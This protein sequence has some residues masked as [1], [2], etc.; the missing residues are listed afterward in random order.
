MIKKVF[1]ILFTF[2]LF[3]SVCRIYGQIHDQIYDDTLPENV[4]SFPF[5]SEDYRHKITY[6][7]DNSVVWSEKK[8]MAWAT[9]QGFS[10]T[11]DQPD[12]GYQYRRGI[13]FHSP[14]LG[15]NLI[16]S[17]SQRGD[18]QRNGWK[19]V[20]DLGVFYSPP[21][22]DTLSTDFKHYENILRY[23]VWIDN[24][25]YKTVEIGYGV[26]LK[27]PLTIEIPYIRD[28]SGVVRV[29]LRMKNHPTNFGILYD[30]F[31]TL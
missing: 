9:A 26:S 10:V 28:S 4:L 17:V 23:E 1:Y 22:E 6:G 25:Y 12:G 21:F 8:I 31:L 20:L 24:I 11:E 2:S 13:I 3:F 5:G 15:F 16:T 18:N 14:G 27:S 30:A 7:L 19:L 29:E